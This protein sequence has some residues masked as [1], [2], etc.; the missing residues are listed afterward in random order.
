M[1][2]LT[3]FVVCVTLCLCFPVIYSTEILDPYLLTLDYD[4]RWLIINRLS[5]LDVLMTEFE[6]LALE[7]RS[8]PIV[9]REDRY[10]YRKRKDYWDLM[11]KDYHDDLL[12]NYFAL[13]LEEE[14]W[15][16]RGPV[17]VEKDCPQ[18][19]VGETGGSWSCLE[20]QIIGIVYFTHGVD[21]ELD[22]LSIK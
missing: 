17:L 11:R 7:S 4:T 13:L 2:R 9:M 3:L 5:E 20:L 19:G 12:W 15:D 14:G 8:F 22:R 18:S 16:V 6:R 21:G 1:S 10:S